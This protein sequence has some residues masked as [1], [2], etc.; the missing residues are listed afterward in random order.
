MA[1]KRVAEQLG[2]TVLKQTLKQFRN[3][4]VKRVAE[5]T[6]ILILPGFPIFMSLTVSE[7]MYNVPLCVNK[8]NYS[9]FVGG[10]LYCS[11]SL[12]VVNSTAVC[13]CGW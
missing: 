12:W 9:L 3:T 10:E 11:L 13:P 7:N 8:T 1:I 6:R 2:K 4:A 5:A